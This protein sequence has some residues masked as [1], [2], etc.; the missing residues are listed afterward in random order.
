MIFKSLQVWKAAMLGL[1][2]AALLPA[3]ASAQFSASY[4]FLKAVKERDG[5]KAT[6]MV[7]KPGSGSVIIDTRD[8]EKGETALHLVTRERDLQWMNFLLGKGANPNVRDNEGNSPLMIATQL[9]FV[10]GVQ[11]LIRARGNV[12]L[13]NSSGETPLIRAVQ[14]RDLGLVRLLLKAG[15]NPD[16][17]DTIAGLSARDY[18]KRDVRGAAILKIIDEPRAKPA[19]AV[20]GPKL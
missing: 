17:A 5:T 1:A 18:A 7:S 4:N 6:E 9:R 13:A 15:S 12:N 2:A 14:Q 16:K 10:E 19:G 20:S 3:A 11:T 8:R